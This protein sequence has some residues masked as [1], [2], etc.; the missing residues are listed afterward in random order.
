MFDQGTLI[1]GANQSIPANMLKS[2]TADI[3]QHLIVRFVVDEPPQFAHGEMLLTAQLVRTAPT[4][5]VS[6]N[7]KL[8]L[9]WKADGSDAPKIRDQKQKPQPNDEDF[10]GIRIQLIKEQADDS[11]ENNR[12]Q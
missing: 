6:I 8:P 7:H 1:V 9:E 10:Y 4:N 3:C 5:L 12:E 11:N 2:P